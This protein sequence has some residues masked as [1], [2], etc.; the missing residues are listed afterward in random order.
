MCDHAYQRTR[1]DLLKRRYELEPVFAKFGISL[2]IDVLKD[3][4]RTLDSRV[5]K[6]RQPSRDQRLNDATVDLTDVVA[7]LE[8]WVAASRA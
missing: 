6:K 1:L 5:F 8:R 7:D 2:N 3:E 4:K